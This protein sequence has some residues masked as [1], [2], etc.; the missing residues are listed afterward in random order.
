V[1]PAAPLIDMS[2]IND[3][4]Q[5]PRESLR[6]LKWSVQALADAASSQAPLFPDR[7]SGPE[8]LAS[9]FDRRLSAVRAQGAEQLTASQSSSLDALAVKLSTM[10]RDGAEFDAE[11]WSDRA[12]RTSEHWTEVRR[13]AEA[14]L[15]AFASTDD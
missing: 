6:L 15:E 13:L 5:D 12:L 14:A 9:A 4:S 10:S 11:L 7:S 8:E 3:D 2:L 1:P